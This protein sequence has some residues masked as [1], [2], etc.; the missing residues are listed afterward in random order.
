L[1][2]GSAQAQRELP[3]AAGPHIR[4]SAPDFAEAKSFSGA[5]R[6][7]G[8]YYFYWYDANTKEHIINGDGTDALTDHPASLEEFSYRS[9]RWHRKELADMIAAGIDVLLPVFWGAPSEHGADAMLHWSYAG[10]PPLVQAREELLRAGKQPPRIG[11]FYDTSTL[12]HNSWREHIDLTTE[13]GKRWFYATIR[14]FF[15]LVPPRHWAMIEGKPIVLLYSA[16]FARKHDQGCIQYVREQFPKD[17]G[18]RVPYLVRE[19]SWRVQAD[20]TCAWGGALG[21]KNPGVAALGPGYDHSAVPGRAPLIVKRDGGQFYA[22]NWLKFLSRP[23]N[24]VMVETWNELHEGTEVCESKEYGRQYIE[25]TRKYATLFKQGWRP[26]T[27]KGQ[28]TGAKSVST[29]LGKENREAGLRQVENDDGVTAAAV[30]AGEEARGL[31]PGT[32]SHYFYFVVD[33]SFKWADVMD[34][35]L[36]VEYYDGAPGALGMEFDG[37]DSSA[38]F[39]GAYSPSADRVRLSGSQ[40]WQTAR[41]QLRRARFLNSQNRGADFRL[42]AGAPEFYVRRVSLG[43]AGEALPPASQ[44][45]EVLRTN[46]HG[47]ADALLL[48][49]STAEII[50]VPALGRVMQFRF[51]GEEGPFWENE[52]L[53]GKAPDPKSSEWGNFGGDKTWP[54]PQADWPK[55]TPRDWPPPAAFDSLPVEAK[56]EG[57]AVTLISLVDPHYGIRTRRHIELDRATPV[58]RIAT[59]YEKVA[60]EP[61]QVGV[62]IITQ[63]R[64]PLAVYAP[65]PRASIFPPGYVKQSGGLPLDLKVS[66]GLLSLRRHPQRSEKVGTDAGALLWVGEKVMVLIESPRLPGVQYP[67][68]GSSAEVYTNPD[69]LA[70]VE[71]EL[72]GPLQTL[73]PGEKTQR[74]STYTLLRRTGADAQTDAKQVLGK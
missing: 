43:R 30:M 41:F 6:I 8:T 54:A 44:A 62:W 59:D 17:F 52:R 26:P 38:P 72:L 32:P 36:E 11:M 69:P 34:A 71:L 50:I 64:D 40:T 60:G 33:D 18:G 31:K 29:T 20:N 58:M 48:R 35:V 53:F 16:A 46:Y 49:N 66:Q 73:R 56:V 12:Q 63:L 15:S 21:L 5:D 24:F 19:V 4:L 70:Y 9:A 2:A 23:C 1:A 25:L 7:V 42:V 14:D 51:A 45:V 47:W 37:S 39:N 3:P 55:M 22:A 28:Y 74:S 27:P 67:D 13:F 65:L 68:A 57:A 10:L 61:C